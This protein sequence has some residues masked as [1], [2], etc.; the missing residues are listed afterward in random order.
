MNNQVEG[1]APDVS[2]IMPAH[3]TAGFLDEAV[4]SV[5]SQTVQSWELLIVNDRSTDGTL[6]KAKRWAELDQRIQALDNVKEPPGAATARNT[7][8]ELARGRFIA[9]LDSDDVWLPRKLETQIN[10]FKETGAALV[11]SS[12]QVIDEQGATL[13]VRIPKSR[14]GYL[15]LLSRNEIGCLTAVYDTHKVGKLYC[16]M[17]Y[18]RN[19]Y[20]IWLH[21]LRGGGMAVGVA[22]ALAKYRIRASSLGSSKLKGVGNLWIIYRKYERLSLFK[23]ASLI[24]RYF[25]M[26]LPRW[27]SDSTVTKRL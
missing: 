6:E 22:D 23:S 14:I 16:P 7:A 24:A 2:V 1:S 20:G 10:T 8:I 19:D 18:N 11:H 12:Y 15:E 5:R 9:F 21:A 27:I 13:G 4:Q 26:N 3:N 17:V 25:C